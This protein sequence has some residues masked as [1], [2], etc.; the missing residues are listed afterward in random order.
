MKF[1]V[2]LNNLVFLRLFQLLQHFSFLI[3]LIFNNIFHKYQINTKLTFKTMLFH[4][5]L[6]TC[7]FWAHIGLYGKFLHFPDNNLQS[8][9]KEC[10]SNTVFADDCFASIFH[11]IYFVLKFKCKWSLF[12]CLYFLETN[13]IEIMGIDI[14]NKIAILRG[15]MRLKSFLLGCNFVIY[16]VH[17]GK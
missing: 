12:M 13:V 10:E 4:L 11:C 5:N 3:L 14:I 2:L 1:I 9:L 17:Q 15:I 16:S 6:W 7:G 8:C